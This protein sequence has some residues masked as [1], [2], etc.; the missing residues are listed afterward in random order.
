VRALFLAFVL[1]ATPLAE[2]VP[3]SEREAVV[4]LHGLGRGPRSMRRLERRLE[5]AGYT[6]ANL[7]YDSTEK[8]FDALVE[9]LGRTLDDLEVD[10]AP[11]LHFVTFS[12]GGIVLRGYLAR[13]TPAN[14]GRIVMIAPPNHGSEIVDAVGDERWFRAILGPTA[15]VLGTSPSSL[16]SSLPPPSAEFGVIAA[17]RSWNPIGSWLIPGDDDGAVSIESTRLAG[18]T[19]HLVVKSNHTLVKNDREVAAAVVRFLERGRFSAAPGSRRPLPAPTVPS[20]PP[21]GAASGAAG[22][23]PGRAAFASSSASSSRSAPP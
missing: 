16:P 7:R 22:E 18:M 4:L 15:A 6:V 14:L 13:E 23:S 12:L 10:R 21:A 5:D 1:V 3:A 19:D 8:D 2:V 9:D 17:S 11:R 20:A